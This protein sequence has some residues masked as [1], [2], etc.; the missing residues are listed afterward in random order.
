MDKL[1]EYIIKYF[2]KD[3]NVNPV[4]ET[5]TVFMNDYDTENI[6]MD[7]VNND[8]MES[9][10]EN[11]DLVYKYLD[12]D[13]LSKEFSNERDF[14]QDYHLKLCL[15]SVNQKLKKPFIEY[16]FVYENEQFVFPEVVL[17]K[18]L[19]QDI[20]K[21]D[22]NTSSWFF[23]S[24]PEIDNDANKVIDD[25]FI[26]QV[27]ETFKHCTKLSHQEGIDNYR[28]FIDHEQDIFVF[29]DC[30]HLNITTN[31]LYNTQNNGTFYKGLHT[32]ILQGSLYQQSIEPT[33]VSVFKEYSFLTKIKDQ[34]DYDIEN[35]ITGYLCN[36]Q[37]N[38]YQNVVN[39]DSQIMSLLT[40]KV[41]HDLFGYI[42]IFSENPLMNDIRIKRY[43]LFVSPDIPV[44]EDIP[45]IMKDE[46]NIDDLNNNH[47]I[48]YFYHNNQKMI[49]IHD[50]TLF[51]E[52]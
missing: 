35:P 8:K 3:S 27:I 1:K 2:M 10:V 49:G 26:E 15:F 12:D 38:T 14:S 28:G 36:Y 48:F 40:E 25:I 47:N 7:D 34:S 31:Q 51:T 24:Q 9:I 30:T 42:Y 22:D 23:S 18:D 32:D 11:N 33:I 20:F 4:S 19:F 13:I 50:K 39:E 29:F 6:L 52:L 45:E 21:Q 44:L 41:E 43:A 37:D 16:H 17:L 46:S 5:P